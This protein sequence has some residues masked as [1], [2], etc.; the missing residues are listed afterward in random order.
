MLTGCCCEFPV[1][2]RLGRLRKLEC[3]NGTFRKLE[4]LLGSLELRPLLS[5]L[6]AARTPATLPFFAEEEEARVSAAGNQ[7]RRLRAAHVQA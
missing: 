4:L 1:L 6:R 5:V 3:T 7:V 2:P